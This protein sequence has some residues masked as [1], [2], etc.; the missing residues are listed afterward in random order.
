[1]KI[2]VVSGGF[3]PLHSGHLAYIKE[4]ASYGD[5]LFVC[6][7]S[8]AWLVAKKGKAFL[9]FNERKSIL[10]SIR[11]VDEV[12][13][14]DDS[15]GSCIDGLKTIRKK[16]IGA[17]VIFCNGGDR[18]ND[19]TPEKNL[20]DISFIFNDIDTLPYKKNLL[21]YST[22]KGEIK[23]YYGYYFAL[24]GIVSIKGEDF[25]KINGFPNYW[26]YGY[27]DNIL[28]KRA[29]NNNLIVNRKQFYPIGSK[30]ILQFYDGIK[31][32]MNKH[33]INRQINKSH[34][35]TDGLNTLTDINYKYDEETNMLNIYNFNGLYNNNDFDT[36]IHSL[37][38]GTKV[39]Y[40]PLSKMIFHR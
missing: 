18:N 16:F 28:H 21:N 27:E 1:M 24:G 29:I 20:K 7:N 34:V 26:G 14:I 22:I 17:E 13:R 33:N 12:F 31:K 40:N 2:A 9:P 3:D 37:E 5:K 23:H 6:L 39:K 15:D 36:H 4:A 10:E 8:D 30:E 38:N 32:V 35:E 25:E 19:N 11:Y